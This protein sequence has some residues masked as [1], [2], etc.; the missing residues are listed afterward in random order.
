MIKEKTKA[1][2]GNGMGRKYPEMFYIDC[3]GAEIVGEFFF[4]VFHFLHC[5]FIS[6]VIKESNFCSQNPPAFSHRCITHLNYFPNLLIS[7]ST[8]LCFGCRTR[9]VFCIVPS[10]IELPFVF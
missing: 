7:C 1:C 2:V 5:G 3:Q 4:S 8:A 9:F 10:L 6:S